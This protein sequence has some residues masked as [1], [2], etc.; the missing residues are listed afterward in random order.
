MRHGFRRFLL[1]LAMT[2]ALVACGRGG[3]DEIPIEDRSAR[4]IFLDAE[5]A[6]ADS[7]PLA[8]A[9][10][11]EE[12]ERLYPYS[13]WAR[14]SVIMSAFPTTR[15]NASPSRVTRRCGSWTSTRRTRT[16]PMHNT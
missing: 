2:L 16:R 8:A 14:R 4:E 15:P 3:E 1:G 11:F 10:M 12:V 13:P 5:V 9:R 6:L 7:R